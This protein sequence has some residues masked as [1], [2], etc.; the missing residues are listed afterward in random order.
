MENKL[1][2]ALL[3]DADNASYKS[4]NSILLFVLN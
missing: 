4:I 2:F 3:I 1:N